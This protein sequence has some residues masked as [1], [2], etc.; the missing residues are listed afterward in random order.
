LRLQHLV[1]PSALVPLVQEPRLR[2]KPHVMA[3]GL[4]P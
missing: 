2:R 1:S 4:R 3:I